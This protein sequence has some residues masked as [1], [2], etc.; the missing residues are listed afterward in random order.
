MLEGLQPSVVVHKLSQN[1]DSG[2]GSKGKTYFIVLL[3]S[4]TALGSQM[5]FV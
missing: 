4:K 3:M 2:Y 1:W 5:S